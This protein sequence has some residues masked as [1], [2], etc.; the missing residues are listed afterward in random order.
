M[1]QL[2]VPVA[3]IEY[4][5]IIQMSLIFYCNM[6]IDV[7]DGRY[8]DVKEI[9]AVMVINF[10]NINKTNNHLYYYLTEYIKTTTYDVGNTGP[11]LGQTHKC[12]G[13]N[14]LM[15]SQ[16]SSLDKNVPT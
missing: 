6:D 4:I 3:S 7:A 13:L 11:G 15:G 8:V 16:P 10:T 5:Q 2:E 14:R 1:F 9:Y 12:G